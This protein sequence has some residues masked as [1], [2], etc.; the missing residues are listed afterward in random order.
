MSMGR[1]DGKVAIV[2]GAA[3][4]I[5]RATAET[6]AREGAKVVVADINGP[7]AAEVA[8]GIKAAGGESMAF[9]VDVSDANAVA[10]M[11][12]AAV[13]T[14]GGLHILHNNAALTSPD[15]HAQD[16]SVVD[17]DLGAWQ[18]SLEVNLG[19]AMLGCRFAV[20][21]MIRSGGGSIINTASNQGLAGDLT[22]TAY[23]TAKGA[24]ITLSL[25]VATQYGKQNVRCNVVSPGL[26]LTPSALAA[27][28]PEILD[29]IEKSNLLP[30]NGHAQDLAN[31]VLFLASDE[32]SF[33]TGQV[34]RVDGGQLAHLPHFAYLMET[35]TT[36]TARA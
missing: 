29:T 34:I 15:Q 28:P 27:C 22:Q 17:M 21:E 31:A 30:R 20:P 25:F 32:S 7:G 4:G 26:I 1:V 16:L 11:V 23:G 8:S 3:S 9:T 19:G 6:L 12:R 35:G 5:G 2:T 24:V 36:T 33:V 18:R 13:E 14:W 10:G